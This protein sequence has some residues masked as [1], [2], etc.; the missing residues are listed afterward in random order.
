MVKANGSITIRALPNPAKELPNNLLV[1]CMASNDAYEEITSRPRKLNAPYMLN[2]SR[3]TW[4][5]RSGKRFRSVFHLSQHHAGYYNLVHGGIL[6]ALIDDV[7]VEY[8]NHGAPSFRGITR[9][10]KIEFKKPSPPEAFFLAKVS[11]PR[12][13]PF[14]INNSDKVWVECEIWAA[15]NGEKLALVVKAETLFVLR[16]SIPGLLNGEAQHSI[17]DVLART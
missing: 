17:E 8:C 10:L 14:N 15:P 16:E 9:L 3:R 13:F 11:T 1:E 5:E 12:E 2:I 6:A 4:M 7:S